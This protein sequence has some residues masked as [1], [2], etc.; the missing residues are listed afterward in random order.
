[1]LTD[2]IS[3]RER[4]DKATGHLETPI[5]VIDLAAFDDNAERLA[6]RAGDKPIRVASKSVR[7]RTLL[8]RV[9]SRPGWHGVMAYTLPEALWLVRSGV[10]DDVLVAYPT[11]DRAG[12]RELT[13]HP[14]LAAAIT[15][16]VDH[17]AHLDVVDQVAAPGARPAVRL[18]IDLDASW[19]PAGP[20]H[21]G[22]RRS[23]I[24]SAAQAGALAGKIAERD[25]FRLVG[26][27]CYEAHIAGVGD[28]PPGQALRGRAIRMMQSRAFPELRDRRAAAVRAVREHADLEFVNGGG[29]GSVSA[30]SADPAVTEVTA[31]SGLYGPALFDGY[32]SWRPTPAALFALSVV[33]RPAPRI[34][35]VL[36]GGWIASG[37]PEAS[38]LPVPWLPEGLRFKADEGAGEVQTPLLGEA[39]ERLRPGDR[40]WFRHAKAGE[41]CEHVNELQLVDGTTSTP[42]LTYR[43]EGRAFLG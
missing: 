8:E 4:L 26:V 33:R 3:L 35:T 23:P 42:A 16:M 21:I 36:G 39:A 14:E 7:C 11:V 22:V 41:L 19:R 1:M 29:T 24:H 43:G 12:L 20:L 32:R 13:T 30:T 37:A 6:A 9:L 18:C 15:L 25:G 5:A 27:M 10:T 31:G 2:R 38:R 28:D 34:A 40:V 17:P